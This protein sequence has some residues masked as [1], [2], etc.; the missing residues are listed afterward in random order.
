MSEGK[1]ALREC[2]V[3]WCRSPEPEIYACNTGEAARY[4]VF[5]Q[6][7]DCAGPQRS[8]EAEAIT[9]WNHRSGPINI[10]TLR[11]EIFEILRRHEVS[12]QCFA[13]VAMVTHAARTRPVSEGVEESAA[14]IHAAMVWASEQPGTPRQWQGGNSTA[15][16][17]ARAAARKLATPSP[18]ADDGLVEEL[19]RLIE[20]ARRDV[21]TFERLS[22]MSSRAFVD[23]APRILA[24]LRHKGED[25]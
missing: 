25:R 23:I 19:E 2:P 18:S 10:D 13:E 3:P 24:A 8:T 21:H 4:G 12:E 14:V 17:Y 7:C 9:A 5:C 20:T 6:L 16:D 22:G 1:E 15:E 11:G